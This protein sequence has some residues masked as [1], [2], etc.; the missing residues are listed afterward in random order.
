[1]F[2]SLGVK[3]KGVTGDE[4]RVRLRYEKT[5]PT[6]CRGPLWKRTMVYTVQHTVLVTIVGVALAA[7]ARHSRPRPVPRRRAAVAVVVGALGRGHLLPAWRQRAQPLHVGRL[8]CDRPAATLHLHLVAAVVQR[9]RVE[10]THLVAVAVR[11][12]L[13][14]GWGGVRVRVKVRVGLGLGL[15]LGLLLIWVRSHA[16]FPA[17]R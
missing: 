4:P 7:R 17:G 14:L 12:G 16:P 8:D 9:A 2:V 10:A 3:L 5:K 13:G 1:M 15:G 11:I 6:S